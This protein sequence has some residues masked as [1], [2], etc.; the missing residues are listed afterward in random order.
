[1]SSTK[2][3]SALLLMSVAFM[4]IYTVYAISGYVYE[5]SKYYDYYIEQKSVNTVNY[6]KLS[7]SLL[8]AGMVED[9]KFRLRDAYGAKYIDFFIL[10]KDGEVLDFANPDGD[11]SKLDVEFSSYGELLYFDDVG[12]GAIKA[13][14]YEVAAGFNIAH[15]AYMEYLTE[16]QGD[17][18][19]RD[20]V[21][22]IMFFI[23]IV[24]YFFQDI[25]R[26]LS[27]LKKRNRSGLEKIKYRSSESE[28][29]V[30]GFS[31]YE[32]NLET[33]AYQ[34]DIFQ[35]Q[36]LP[37]IKSEILSGKKP[38]YEFECIL[39]RTDINNFTRIFNQHPVEPFMDVINSFFTEVAATV[40]RYHGYIYEF[41]GD[42]IIYYFKHSELNDAA[43]M[44]IS[45]LR[46]INSI[47]KRYNS[48]TTSGPGYPFV[49]K[50]SLSEGRLRFGAQVS[51]FTL[52]GGVLIESVR[53][54]SQIEEKEKNTM[55]FG[56]QIKN[57]ITEVA[58][59]Q[60]ERDVN[61]KGIKDNFALYSGNPNLT[62]DKVLR[63]VNTQSG[64][65][66]YFRSNSDLT[67]ILN[68]VG[69]NYQ[70]IKRPSLLAIV[71]ELKDVSVEDTPH[72]LLQAYTKLLKTALRN[73]TIKNSDEV[74]YSVSSLISLG[75]SLLSPSACNEELT[76]LLV[77]L[78]AHENP[79]VVANTVELLGHF[80][81]RAV[82][83]HISKAPKLLEMIEK[84]NNRIIANALIKEGRQD[85]SDKVILE[86][87]K[88]L[89]A[90]DPLY[91]AS[92]IYAIGELIKYYVEE[93]IVYLQTKVDFTRLL[94]DVETLKT[95]PHEAIKRQ[96]QT[97]L[98][99]ATP[100]TNQKHA[101]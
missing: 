30:K 94:K 15:S 11:V 26:I 21:I 47:A 78:L 41:V 54:L 76:E 67:K 20:L 60:F 27:F 81:E 89:H 31:G 95:H 9:L 14:D 73:E 68:A 55:Y 28:L 83:K 97:T 91:I 24:F 39:V 18:I 71:K 70:E 46:D 59:S 51:G 75:H 43:N 42:E 25:L 96:S 35:R 33:L 98:K 57:Q 74:D 37:G 85:L 86:I 34:K 62:I 64:L 19:L 5:S 49:V 40:T 93:D 17:V 72:D 29:L 44:A 77:T 12:Y 2:R 10:R 8:N 22:V 36:V 101:S 66:R 79:R 1:M 65:V 13:G 6:L 3:R 38:P 53:I 90:D 99:A 100:L 16:E 56:E 45:A 69:E 48:E 50:S 58:E 80:N 63:T 82:D 7:E 84:E 88:M 92:A 87:R 61:L 52:A 32:K 23:F 4:V